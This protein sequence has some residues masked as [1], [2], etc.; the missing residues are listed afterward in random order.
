M[1]L[2]HHQ[3][4]RFLALPG[5]VPG[6]GFELALDIRPE[7]SQD[8]DALRGN[9]WM[10][11]DPRRVASTPRAFNAYVNGSAAEFSVAQGVYAEA[12]SGWFSDRTAAYLAAGRPALVQETGVGDVLPVGEGL[13][14]FSS[15]EEAVSGVER[16][17]ADPA[18]HS[19]AARRLATEHL[20]SEVV[21]GRLLAR[22]GIGG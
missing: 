12:R 14:T 6:A 8:L 4:R 22:L 18:S 17:V 7:D 11:A 2:K 19:R 15:P 16:I 3:F 13:L 10:L 20:D 1:G 9:G 21:L 5:K